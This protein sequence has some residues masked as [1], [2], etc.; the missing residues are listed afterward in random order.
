M[1]SESEPV[2]VLEA[3]RAE[4]H[5]W[6]DLWRYRELFAILAW[7]DLAVRYKQTAIGVAWAVVRPALTVAIFT[8]VFG[9]VAK[10]PSEGTAEAW[11]K[12]AIDN[13]PSLNAAQEQLASAEANVA[14]ARAGHLPT[15][16]LN[17]SYGDSKTT[18]TRDFD[19]TAPN[20]AAISNTNDI[21]SQSRG[22]SVGITLNVPIFSGGA[23]SSRVRQAIANRDATADVVEQQRRALERNTR[24]AYQSL[25]AG[26]SEVEARR[27]ALTSARSA[28]EAS[29]VGLEVGTRTVLDVL[30][31]QQ[32]LFNA[33]RAY[34]EARYNFL[35]ARL[36][37]EQAA[38]TLDAADVQDVNRLLT[39]NAPTP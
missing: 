9:R 25:V 31:N 24:A 1:A 6:E 12:K 4:R 30:N 39:A 32:N 19:D 33:Q 21:D 16:Y 27:S 36:N 13:N 7:R 20:G 28:F 35:Q 37:L 34:A 14:T 2:I 5:Y 22:P 26:I 3:G 10:L 18:G 23:T 8:L 11:V 17:G 29:Q 15:V 38:G